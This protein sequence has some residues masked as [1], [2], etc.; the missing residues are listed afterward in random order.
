M[1]VV[2]TRYKCLREALL[3]STKPVLLEKGETYQQFLVIKS[4]L[5]G[6]IRC[7]VNDAQYMK[8]ALMYF[9]DITGLRI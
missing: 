9:A 2:G 8:R 4:A 7:N 6:A 5:S 1:Y 3:R